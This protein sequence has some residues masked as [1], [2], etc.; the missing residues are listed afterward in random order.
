MPKTTKIN[1]TGKVVGKLKHKGGSSAT[2]YWDANAPG[3]GLKVTAAGNRSFVFQKRLGTDVVRKKIGDVA[4]WTLPQAQAEARK[5]ARWVDQ[6]KDPQEEKRKV[7]AAQKRD[8]LLV[9]EV[10]DLFLSENKSRW[11]DRHYKDNVRHS[12]PPKDGDSSTQ[13]VLWPLLT[14]R[15]VDV[16][17]NA[18]V[19]WQKGAVKAFND[20]VAAVDKA[21]EEAEEALK[22]WEA[23]TTKRKNAKR[24]KVKVSNIGT[25]NAAL[26]QGFICF[27][28]FWNWID[29]LDEYEDIADPKIFKHP[30]LKGITNQTP[31][32]D[33]LQKEDLQA[34]FTAVQGISNPS[35]SAYIQILLL[36]GCR[37]NELTRLT[38]DRVK[39]E[40]GEIWLHDKVERETGR[41]I[42]LTPYV[43]HLL[44]QLP[45]ATK[46]D[47]KLN[48]N[49]KGYVFFSPT[50]K[51]GHLEEPRIPYARALKA[52]GVEHVSLHGL[53]RSFST[54]SEWM[55][56]IPKG[57]IAQVQGHKPSATIERYYRNRPIDMLAEWIQKYETWILE[58]AGISFNPDTV[59]GNLKIIKSE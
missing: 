27:R 30:S 59:G 7:K 19:T 32:S 20:K 12:R 15:L 4:T 43:Y 16:D 29:Q 58:K 10:W 50:A 5:L 11:S 26:R 17:A 39:F 13:G 31:K 48:P 8:S 36:L 42:P 14:L 22:R 3:L 46:S 6:G 53:R 44:K 57:I 23:D 2:Y 56:G 18:L 38:W 25:S 52:A 51:S 40:K 33:S 35:I 1:F 49:V 47:I 9:K 21:R 37:R 45:K 55:I 34:W 54:L 41:G 24:P 28:A